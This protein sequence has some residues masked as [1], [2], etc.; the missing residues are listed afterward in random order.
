MM[1]ALLLYA[2][3]IGQRSSRRIER[4]CVGTS[5]RADLR[6]QGLDHTAIARFRQRH[7][8][9]LA[10]CPAAAVAAR[11]P[12]ATRRAARRGRSAG[13]SVAG[14]AA[15]RGQAPRNRSLRRW[16]ESRGYSW[17]SA[18]PVDTIAD[19]GSPSEEMCER[20]P[21]RLLMREL[22][23][24]RPSIVVAFRRGTPT[25]R[26]TAAPTSHGGNAPISVTHRGRVERAS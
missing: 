22:T 8:S 11:R 14:Q 1:V 24:L 17:S 9:A 25:V 20:C 16:S 13:A 26:S 3:G 6:E 7:E 19:R 2:Y 12:P 4:R 5:R 23:V 21:A 15:G 18:R 10:G